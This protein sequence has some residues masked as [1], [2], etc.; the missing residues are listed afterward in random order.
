[1]AVYCLL[2]RSGSMATCVDDMIGGFNTF[3]ETLDRH[4]KIS[5]YLFDNEFTPVYRNIPV[6]R[7]PKLSHET[8][9]PRG[10]TALLDSIGKILG[11]AEP[12]SWAD[13]M[14]STTIVILT[15]GEDTSSYQF[16][17]EEINTCISQKKADGWKFI[18]MGSNQDAITTASQLNI[19]SGGALTFSSR[20]LDSAFRSVSSAVNRSGT[21]DIQFSDLERTLSC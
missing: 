5:L 13:D 17:L 3:I 21:N 12:K 20:N 1:M 9:Q 18:F 10:S 14:D 7:A 4:L 15:D 8:Y 16:T 19:D 6:I 2:D 11:I